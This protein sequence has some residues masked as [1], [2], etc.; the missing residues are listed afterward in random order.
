MTAEQSSKR[1]LFETVHSRTMERRLGWFD[2]LLF[3]FGINLSGQDR[4]RK[5][6]IVLTIFAYAMTALR[7]C[8]VVHSIWTSAYL[9]SRIAYYASEVIGA[10]I[11][12]TDMIMKRSKYNLIVIR[13]MNYCGRAP[14]QQVFQRGLIYAVVALVLVLI[15]ISNF[16]NYWN[17]KGTEFLFKRYFLITVGSASPFYGLLIAFVFFCWSFHITGFIATSL[18]LYSLLCHLC[19]KCDE[20]CLGVHNVVISK[21]AVDER[22]LQELNKNR[23]ELDQLKRA[24]LKQLNFLPFVAYGLSF[25]QAILRVV[26]ITNENSNKSTTSA[27]IL[28]VPFFIN[29]GLI[30][31]ATISADKFAKSDETLVDEITF[32]LTKAKTADCKAD[33]QIQLML[34]LLSQREA[35]KPTIWSFFALNKSLILSFCGASISFAALCITVSGES[36]QIQQCTC[37]C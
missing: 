29:L 14:G 27:I 12:L 28:L 36:N 3:A 8:V 7:F 9:V 6:L 5:L 35:I 17:E 16:A 13:L 31:F 21:T 34:T 11:L 25:A 20:V 37:K 23:T 2:W 1:V 18:M 22:D 24:L 15:R 10:A 4:F 32:L 19:V 30:T 26:S 33:D